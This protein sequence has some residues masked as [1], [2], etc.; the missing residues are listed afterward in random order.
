M[1]LPSTVRIRDLADRLRGGRPA[2]TVVSGRRTVLVTGAA[3]GLGLALVRRFTARGD[4]VLAT[5]RDESLEPGVLPDGVAYQRLDVTDDADWAAARAWVEQHFGHLDVLVN[6]A[7]IA[8]GGRIEV[9][10]TADWE[11]TVAVNLLGAARGCH[12][13]AAMFKAQRAGHIVNTASLAGLVHGPVMASYN[14]TKAGVVA[15]SETLRYELAPW[16]VRVSV[17]CPS[18]FRTNLAASFDG[19][20]T[21]AEQT[22]AQLIN[23]APRSA[24]T[25][26][27][28]VVA[29]M[30][31]GLPTILTDRDGHAVVW[32]KRLARPAY[33]AALLKAGR[34]VAYRELHEEPGDRR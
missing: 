8:A 15:L 28:R 6:N 21:E 13:F 16:D 12:A 25:V 2:R 3:S 30:D 9:S 18:F 31:A 23:D 11:R 27:R 7:G 5:D 10:T 34:R 14:A 20:D 19:A 33:D 4:E 1:H 26:A 24:D 29:G 17:I 22:G 32:T